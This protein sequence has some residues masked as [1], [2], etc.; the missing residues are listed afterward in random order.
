[1]RQRLARIAIG[2]YPQAWRERYGAEVAVLL[3]DSPPGPHELADLLRGAADAHLHPGGLQVSRLDRMRNTVGAVLCCWIAF[4]LA[5]AGFAKLTEDQSYG[6]AEGAHPLLADARTAVAALAAFSAIAVALAGAPLV[7]TVLRE[8]WTERRRGLVWA[9]LVPP[10]A[11]A[12]FVIVGGTLI[13][14]ANERQPDHSTF[15]ALVF[16]A[17]AA[18]GLIAAAACGLGSRTALLRSHPSCFSLRVGVFGGCAVSAAMAAVAVGELLYTGALVHFAP[19]LAAS[20]SGP[21]SV[22]TTLLLALN[23]LTMGA[24][25]ALA[26]ISTWRGLRAARA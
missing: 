1:M 18:S 9:V 11:I 6:R 15:N 5:G 21:F 26:A 7:F 12:G 19:H 24:A 8:A 22:D 25:T 4:V 2:L 3:E 20:A 10:I 16:C 14:V 13:W 23:S 17:L